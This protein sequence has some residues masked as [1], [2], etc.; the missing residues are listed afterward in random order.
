MYINIKNSILLLLVIFIQVFHMSCKSDNQLVLEAAIDEFEYIRYK[1]PL[2]MNEIEEIKLKFESIKHHDITALY[3]LSEI[4][5]LQNKTQ[6][7]YDFISEAYAISHA[8]SIY[9]Q[10]EKIKELMSINKLVITDPF[11][12]KE[13]D[14]TIKQ[15]MET[16]RNDIQ[17]LYNDK[18]YLSAIN[19]TKMLIQ[20]IKDIKEETEIKNELS[21]LYQDLAVLYAKQNN[22]EEANSAINKAIELNPSKENIDLKNLI[23]KN[24]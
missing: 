8:D 24:S 6:E 23:N 5:I 17:K 7:A 22:I 20:L 21:Q 11:S 16:G 14:T 1:Q 3:Y 13:Y 18:Q 19:N 12:K 4:S 9:K 10:K 2:E 15:L